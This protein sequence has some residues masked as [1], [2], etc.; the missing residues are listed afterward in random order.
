[1]VTRFARR[2]QNANASPR[3][4]MMPENIQ[5]MLTAMKPNK[6]EIG[7]TMAGG[8]RSSDYADQ[9]DEERGETKPYDSARVVGLEGGP[10][11]ANRSG[12]KPG[13][14]A[15]NAAY[16]PHHERRGAHVFAL[17]CVLDTIVIGPD[18]S[19]L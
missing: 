2:P 18:A 1:M 12:Q 15:E 17:S 14:D 9:A 3:K 10:G 19:K 4:S 6:A 7:W 16:D 5:N 8:Q 11:F 13:E